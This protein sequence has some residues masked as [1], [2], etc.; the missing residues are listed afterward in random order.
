[1]DAT[2][3]M[4]SISEASRTVDTRFVD[5]DEYCQLLVSRRNLQRIKFENENLYGLLDRETSSQ[6]LIHSCELFAKC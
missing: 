1:M 6:F 3:K 4:D 5:R 2:S